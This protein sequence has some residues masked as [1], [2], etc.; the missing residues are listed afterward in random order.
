MADDSPE[1]GAEKSTDQGFTLI[2]VDVKADVF[3][4]GAIAKTAAAKTIAKAFA[5][6]CNAVS[7]PAHTYMKG[8]AEISVEARRIERLAQAEAKAALIRDSSKKSDEAQLITGPDDDIRRRAGDRL[9]ASEVRKQINLEEAVAEAIAIANNSAPKDN[10]GAIPPDWMEQWAEGAQGASADQVRLFYSKILADKAVGNGSGIP[11]PSLRL[12]REFDSSI[13]ESFQHFARFLSIYGCYPR[14]R[15]V[16]P[17]IISNEIL[18]LMIEIGVIVE[19]T[20]NSFNFT[21]G[22]VSL[23]DSPG[24]FQLSYLHSALVL[25][26]RSADIANVI[27]PK[28]TLEESFGPPPDLIEACTTYVELIEAAVVESFSKQIQLVF[29]TSD[30]SDGG[31]PIIILLRYG[32]DATCDS[33]LSLFVARKLPLDELQISILRELES[34]RLLEGIR[35]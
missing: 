13:A 34:K 31:V 4:F 16:R 29:A 15:S 11:G 20:F 24:P 9:I 25:S 10:P 12:L 2:K 27:W 18:Q 33:L 8:H 26:Q 7:D 14:Y 1:K 17:K 23:H 22:S 6:I 19:C 35:L 30:G 28:S 3:G 32:G 21:I 5:G